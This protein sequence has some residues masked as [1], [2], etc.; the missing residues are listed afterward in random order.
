M[1]GHRE[2]KQVVQEAEEWEEKVG[3]KAFFVVSTRSNGQDRVN[4]NFS[5]FDS[6]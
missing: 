5:W 3:R 2:P 6:L 1:P 4:G